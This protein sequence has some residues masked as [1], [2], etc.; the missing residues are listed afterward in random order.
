MVQL[1]MLGSTGRWLG[2]LP[3]LAL[4]RLAGSGA[5]QTPAQS[6]E[7]SLLD[8]ETSLLGNRAQEAWQKIGAIPESAATG[9]AAAGAALRYYALKMRIALAAAR[10]VDGT[11]AE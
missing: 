8:A 1:T 5:P 6:L 9:S 2:G 10:P 7:R 4:A 11:R 3:P